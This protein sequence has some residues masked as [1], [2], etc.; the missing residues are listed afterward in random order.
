MISLHNIRIKVSD[1]GR[2]IRIEN[3]DTFSL[4]QSGDVA[5]EEG[6]NR[7]LIPS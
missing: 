5:L 4:D 3:L 6:E 2:L 1:A 7:N